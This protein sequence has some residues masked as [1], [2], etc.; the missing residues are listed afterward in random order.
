MWLQ[1]WRNCILSTNTPTCGQR[2]IISTFKQ[3]ACLNIIIYHMVVGFG[4]LNK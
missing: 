2:G 1:L 4:L 3:T